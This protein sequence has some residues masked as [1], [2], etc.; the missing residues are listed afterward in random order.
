MKEIAQAG[1]KVIEDCYDVLQVDAD[2]SDVESDEEIEPEFILEA[3]VICSQ[4]VACCCFRF[5]FVAHYSA[6]KKNTLKKNLPE[7][8]QLIK[9]KKTVQKTV[10]NLFFS[11]ESI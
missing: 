2:D 7:K 10:L 9:E 8:T 4:I 6:L 1:L 3:K 5:I 11:F